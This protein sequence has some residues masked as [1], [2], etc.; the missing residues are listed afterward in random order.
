MRDR[1]PHEKRQ[2]HYQH[3]LSTPMRRRFKLTATLTTGGSATCR[4]LKWNG[5][6]WVVM[7]SSGT[8]YDANSDFFGLTDDFGVAEWFPESQRWE[9]VFL[10]TYPRLGKTDAAHGKGASGTV[11]IWTGTLGGETDTGVNVT[12][13]NRFAAVAITKWVM[14]AHNG[15]GWY[16]IAAEC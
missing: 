9:V 14:V 13:Y 12:A 7:S 6:A 1:N 5:S 11:S 2:G 8:V 3:F 10:P 16:L 4:W 15:V